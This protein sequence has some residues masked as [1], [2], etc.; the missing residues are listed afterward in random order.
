MNDV[1][2]AWLLVGFVAGFLVCAAF[3]LHI[4]RRE[5]RE[6]A[7]IHARMLAR[8]TPPPVPSREEPPSAP[9]VR[10]PRRPLQCAAVLE[11]AEFAD[12]WV[13]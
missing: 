2:F 1:D 8:A 13:N 9:R 5:A 10:Y 6:M 3:V 12:R 7:K 11:R 4:G